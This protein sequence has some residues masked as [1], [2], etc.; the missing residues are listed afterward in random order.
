V[1]VIAGTTAVEKTDLLLTKMLSGEVLSFCWF[2][3]G[4]H[5]RHNES[6]IGRPGVHAEGLATRL[7]L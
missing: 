2:C 7:R 1:L 6:H 5:Q 4:R 3:A